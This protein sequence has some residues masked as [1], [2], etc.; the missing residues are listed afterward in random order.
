MATPQGRTTHLGYH[1]P[2]QVSNPEPLDSESRPCVLI[3]TLTGSVAG[4]QGGLAGGPQ[5]AE[6][7]APD[8]WRRRPD[9]GPAGRSERRSELDGRGSPARGATRTAQSATDDPPSAGRACLAGVSGRTF[10]PARPCGRR[11]GLAAPARGRSLGPGPGR[12]GAAV[13]ITQGGLSH[14]GAGRARATRSAWRVRVGLGAAAGR[15][16]SPCLLAQWAHAPEKTS[17][18]VSI[19]LLRARLGVQV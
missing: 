15:E 8:Q 14:P 9:C 19:S 12:D 4:L 18:L 7:G 10:G 3:T 16:W 17:V 13:R 5:R 1:T 2:E 11:R 6:S